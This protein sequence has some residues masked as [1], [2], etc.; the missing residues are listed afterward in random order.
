MPRRTIH[1]PQGPPAPPWLQRLRDA[2]FLALPAVE[3]AWTWEGQTYVCQR[4]LD[5]RGADVLFSE[6]WLDPQTYALQKQWTLP[7]EA[8]AFVGLHSEALFQ[9]HVTFALQGIA[10]ARPVTRTVERL[11]TWQPDR[12]AARPAQGRRLS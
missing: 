10:A 8:A 12:Y 5:E 11:P 1:P 6:Q 2:V 9:R 7:L 4:H 3:D